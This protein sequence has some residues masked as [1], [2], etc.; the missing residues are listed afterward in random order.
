LALVSIFHKSGSAGASP[1]QNMASRTLT[2]QW[3]GEPLLL[4]EVSEDSLRHEGRAGEPGI[5]ESA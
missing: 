2:A 4:G 3:D 5:E 1:S